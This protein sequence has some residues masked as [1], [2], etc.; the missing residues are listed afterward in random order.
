MKLLNVRFDFTEIVNA[1]L[2]ASVLGLECYFPLFLAPLPQPTPSAAVVPVTTPYGVSLHTSC[3]VHSR[4]SHH[5][6]KCRPHQ[7]GVGTA[8]TAH[9]TRI[10]LHTIPAAPPPAFWPPA[11]PHPCPSNV[12]SPFH[13]ENE[14][15]PL[16]HCP[17]DGFSPSPTLCHY[18]GTT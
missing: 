15:D 6:R 8:T 16:S 3:P 17:S 12:H 2:T 14:S 7:G 13:S 1:I 9:V 18:Q 11:Q 10:T 4:T 5:M